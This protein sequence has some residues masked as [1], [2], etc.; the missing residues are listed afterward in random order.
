[1][2]GSTCN[3]LHNYSRHHVY[4]NLRRLLSK[5][6]MPLVRGLILYMHVGIKQFLISLRR[7]RRP[8]TGWRLV[9]IPTCCTPL[10]GPLQRTAERCRVESGRTVIIHVLVLE[11]SRVKMY[12]PMQPLKH[13][14]LGWWKPTS[15]LPCMASRPWLESVDL[16][17]TEPGRHLKNTY[18]CFCFT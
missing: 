10:L 1:M 13:S 17:R 15:S 5:I 11:M 2:L 16:V 14:N 4:I 6:R 3:A 12:G 18:E 8:F 7:D 9:M